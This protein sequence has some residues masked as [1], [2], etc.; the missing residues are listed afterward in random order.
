MRLLLVEDDR[1]NVQLFTEVLEGAG[2]AVIVERDG[3]AGRDR[4]LAESFDLIIFDIQL[5]RLSGTEICAALRAADMLI[6]I[7]AISAAA[8]PHE[9]QASLDAGFTEYHTKP[10]KPADLR[11]TVDRVL[12]T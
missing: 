2:H 9:V 10:I 5:P 3:I 12:Q 11:T 6:P 7:I 1:A 8:L 4:A